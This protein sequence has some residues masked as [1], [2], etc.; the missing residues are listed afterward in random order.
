MMYIQG[1]Y[2]EVLTQSAA[3]ITKSNVF[4]ASGLV[5]SY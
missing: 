4:T 1:K 3:I 2:P 5:G